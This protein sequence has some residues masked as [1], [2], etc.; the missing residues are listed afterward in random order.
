MS[1]RLYMDA[2]V[3]YAITRALSN[4]GI[5]VLT[6]Q[7]DGGDQLPDDRLMDRATTLGRVLFS[8]DQDMLVIAAD[9]QR[10]GHRFSGLIFARPHR[11]SIARCVN[12]LELAVEAYD[13]DEMQDRVEYLPL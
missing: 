11:V 10:S 3:H 7:D 1:L 6:A 12:D 2:H 13:L 9:R 4:R 8:N 5:D